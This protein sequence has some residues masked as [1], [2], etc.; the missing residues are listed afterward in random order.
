MPFSTC[1]PFMP[2]FRLWHVYT[3][4][5][6]Y[7]KFLLKKWILALIDTSTRECGVLVKFDCKIPMGVLT[8]FLYGGGVRV[9]IW[10]LRYCNKIIFGVC[11]LQL[12]KISI[13]G[14][15]VL[16]LKTNAMFFAL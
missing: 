13:F 2:T 6:F 7:M 12:R 5:V 11:E 14:A 9:N 8:T 3:R 4:D 15:G 1:V 16:T 10:G